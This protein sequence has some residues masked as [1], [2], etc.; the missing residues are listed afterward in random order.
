M[1]EVSSGDATTY[2]NAKQTWAKP[3]LNVEPLDEV[4][5]A[6]VNGAVEYPLQFITV[7]NTSA[8]WL[9]GKQNMLFRVEEPDGTV[10][11]WG[12]LNYD[13]AANIIYTDVKSDGD[14][15]Y[16]TNV[17]IT[18]EDD[19]VVRVYRNR[20][21]WAMI[22]RVT[23]AGIQAKRWQNYYTNEGSTPPPVCIMG[24]DQ[25]QDVDTGTG[26]A[27]FSFDASD[28]YAWEGTATISTYLYT[29][30]TGASVT[31]GSINTSAVTFTI[32]A[33]I[34]TVQCTITSSSGISRSGYRTI[35]AND[36]SSNKSFG[37]NYPIEAIGGDTTDMDG[38]EGQFT[39][40]GDVSSVIY[41]GAK[42]HWYVPVYYDG[43]RLTDNDAF[44]DVFVGYLSA[45]NITTDSNKVKR[46]TLTFSS[47]LKLGK[48]LPSATQ[49]IE[50]VATPSA[51]TE[52]IAG[53]SDPAY[54]GYYVLQ[55]HTTIIDN[56]DLLYES[57]I[58]DL[59]RRVF[60]FPADNI[61]AHLQIIGQI[62]SGDI[63]C[64]SDGTITL[65]QE[66]SL[67]KTADRD[68]RDDKFTWTEDNVQDALTISPT[69]RPKIA[70]LIMAAVAYDGNPT[71]PMTAY[72]AKAPGYAQAQGVTKTNL[73]DISITVEGGAAELYG[74]VGHMFALLNNP[75]SK[76]DVPVSK[77]FDI[78][79]PADPDWHTLN[80][81]ESD[82][83]PIN[84]DQF[85]VRWSST[86]R[87]RPTRI[88]RTWTRTNGAWTKNIKQ[89]NRIESFGQAGVFHPTYKG[90]LQPYVD[91]LSGWL[92][93]L[94]IT[95]PD[96]NLDFD[97]AGGGL[98]SSGGW[99]E[100][101]AFNDF[102][103]SAYSADWN[104]SQ[105]SYT[106][107]NANVTGEVVAQCLDGDGGGSAYMITR[108]VSG[109]LYKYNVY[110]NSNIALDPTNWVLDHTF[111]PDPL[112]PTNDGLTLV[113]IVSNA[114]QTMHVS[115]E[116]FDVYYQYKLSGGSWSARA[117]VGDGGILEL[118]NEYSVPPIVLD[119]SAAWTVGRDP[120]GRRYVVMQQSTPGGAWSEV[121]NPL[122]TNG[123]NSVIP[124]IA[125]S[126]TD[127]YVSFP[128]LAAGPGGFIWVYLL[129]RVDDA[130]TTWVD[131]TPAA[132]QYGI[133]RYNALA[134][135][136]ANVWVIGKNP[137][138][139]RKLFTSD[140]TG[141]T[142]T[143]KGE[144]EYDWLIR[145]SS[146]S[147]FALGGDS[148][149]DVTNNAFGTYH[150][151]LGEWAELGSVGIVENFAS[152]GL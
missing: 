54:A 12:V 60:G 127:I 122:A 49:M 73:P 56:H 89:Q 24:H 87:M 72:A 25:Q 77:M 135:D 65:T 99:G 147:V 78:G 38:W 151:R 120:V 63:G 148:V 138:G 47:P 124:M 93:G 59:R 45:I 30:P 52:V 61:T 53:L 68:S 15:G 136:G 40:L 71:K 28:S 110:E 114:T 19:D 33:G 6:D 66:P 145:L 132:G 18:I 81:S 32:A 51:W 26:L 58:R 10:I 137:N 119:G 17:G 94:D 149:L 106:G 150:S 143:D 133:R 90:E 115:V 142:W 3:I 37:E 117:K 88:T 50:E 107:A 21:N 9:D 34:Y 97:T 29:L 129:W 42:C 35:Y 95:M 62:M 2:A 7:D 130:T 86:M 8:D 123:S 48:M 31:G 131:V 152:G 80:I 44:I 57:A 76:L 96:L 118:D 23:E 144:S 134:V 126:G 64:R 108:T 121:E 22:S 125:R 140:N 5:T 101:W 36:T 83:L 85:G 11:C 102:G 67:Q 46:S 100:G 116:K 111:T 105:P 112:P 139:I 103:V 13:N 92:V 41:P 146:N 98:P 16:A 141:N 84:M 128:E 74:I 69:F 43:S 39:V 20:P 79:E 75:L 109:S 4:A 14:F 27:T 113:N 104:S 91:P 82:Y 70:Y 1:S 55:F